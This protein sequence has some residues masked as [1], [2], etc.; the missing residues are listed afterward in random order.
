MS[1]F[2]QYRPLEKNEFIVVGVDTAA[3]GRDSSCAQFFSSLHLDT[4]LVYQR[5]VI[6]PAM[7]DEIFPVLN[8]IYEITGVE[9]IVAYE[10]QNGGLFEMERL[11]RLNRENK[12]RIYLAKNEGSIDNATEKQLG[13][14]TNM[15][16]RPKM[17]ADLKDAV[18]NSLIRVWDKPT[19]S[20][21][22]SFIINKQG[23]PIAE[24]GSHDDLV[25]SL[26]IAWQL[27]Q[28]ERP[29]LNTVVKPYIPGKWKIA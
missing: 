1:G 4:P 14:N 11:S 22:Y 16:T 15:A 19:V 6:A 12:F 20:E 17:L 9:P 23:K 27:Y 21:M 26:A 8:K 13:W 28:T 24:E 25:M 10:R 29:K 2:R 5:N 7:T 3:G 18:D